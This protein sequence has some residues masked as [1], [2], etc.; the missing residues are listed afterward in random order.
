ME[1]N[2]GSDIHGLQQKKK[3]ALCVFMAA[4]SSQVE[5]V[6]LQQLDCITG[7]EPDTLFFSCSFEFKD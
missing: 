6:T 5:G 7:L 1:R 2:K 3:N 4:L